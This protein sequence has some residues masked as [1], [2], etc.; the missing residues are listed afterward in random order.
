MAAPSTR[1]AHVS[2]KTGNFGNP[3][4]L[5][6]NTIA[7]QMGPGKTICQYHVHYNLPIE[8]RGM[9]MRLINEQKELLGPMKIFDG[10]AFHHRNPESAPSMAAD[11][12]ASSRGFV[13]ALYT[14]PF[15]ACQQPMIV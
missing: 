3:V 4:D 11:M 13:A 8:S 5:Y 15:L 12:I 6:T 14:S 10:G 2:V 9:R 1:P 7:I